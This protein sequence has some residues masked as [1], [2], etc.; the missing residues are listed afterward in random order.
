MTTSTVVYHSMVHNPVDS[1]STYRSTAD[2]VMRRQHAALIQLDY[3]QAHKK[4]VETQ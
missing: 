2:K 3:I 1:F 4:P